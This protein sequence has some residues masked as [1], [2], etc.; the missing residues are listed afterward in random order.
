MIVAPVANAGADQVLAQLVR[1]HPANQ[2]LAGE[3]VNFEWGI[4]VVGVLRP[5]QNRGAVNAVDVAPD[6]H[7]EI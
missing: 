6:A 5:A 7:G 2:A 1:D 4:G 3:Q